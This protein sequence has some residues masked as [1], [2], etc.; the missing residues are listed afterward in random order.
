[1][2]A[3]IWTWL[4]ISWFATCMILITHVSFDH[5]WKLTSD[6][7]HYCFNTC[8]SRT[9]TP[10]THLSTELRSR[11]TYI[12]APRFVYLGRKSLH[13][14]RNLQKIQ[15]FWPFFNLLKASEKFRSIRSMPIS[16]EI[17]LETRQVNALLP[18]NCLVRGQ[19]LSSALRNQQNKLP[20]TSMEESLLDTSQ[21]FDTG[22][23]NVCGDH[24]LTGCNSAEQLHPFWSMGPSGS[25]S[26]I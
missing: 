14:L 17:E 9:S 23:A 20:W 25:I 19:L 26:A 2:P 21:G 8:T 22:T 5:R 6:L 11:N 24:I 1:M 12:G 7:N 13:H 10:A 4:T 3:L 18:L 16:V 15:S